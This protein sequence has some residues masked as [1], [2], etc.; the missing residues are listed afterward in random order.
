M[1]RPS[2]IPFPQP[3]AGLSGCALRCRWSHLPRASSSSLMKTPLSKVPS[4][5][6]TSARATSVRLSPVVLITLRRKV[7]F[8]K[9]GAEQPFRRSRL[10]ESEIAPPCP[11]DDFLPA[12]AHNNS[13]PPSMQPI[14]ASCK[15]KKRDDVAGAVDSGES[16]LTFT[17]S[18]SLAKPAAG[19]ILPPTTSSG[20]RGNRT[21]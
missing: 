8:G 17:R 15:A 11:D 3:S 16:G 9:F 4:T 20:S 10:H 6:A 14:G 5:F 2:Q 12:S 19:W 1:S 7:S 13:C 18:N 21:P